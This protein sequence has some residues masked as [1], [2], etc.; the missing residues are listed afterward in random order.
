MPTI[1]GRI[2]YADEDIDEFDPYVEDLELNNFSINIVTTPDSFL[3]RFNKDKWD[4][5]ILDIM[6]PR[7]NIFQRDESK[8]GRRTGLLLLE[9]IKKK[10]DQEHPNYG[11]PII[12]RTAV[13]GN[14]ELQNHCI[15]LGIPPDHYF[16]KPGNLS[17]LLNTIRKDIA[18]RRK[19]K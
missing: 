5:I 8:D 15:K 7:G 14:E 13:T 16:E 4:L 19:V 6:F 17:V 18:S 2:L 11:I 1:K 10:I 9:I 12:I 3:D